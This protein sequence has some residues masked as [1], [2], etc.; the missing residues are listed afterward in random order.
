M[1]SLFPQLLFLSPFAALAIRITLGLLFAFAAWQHLSR[2]DSLSRSLGTFEL[3]LAI[4]LSIGAWTQAVALVGFLGMAAGLAIPKIRAYPISTVLLAL[5]MSAT[6]IVTGA[7]A[8][9]FDLPL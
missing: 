8:F 5:V 6:L 1:L 9:A 4:V 3:A 2:R 7:G